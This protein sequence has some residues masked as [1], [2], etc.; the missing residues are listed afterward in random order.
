MDTTAMLPFDRALIEAIKD[1]VFIVSAEKNSVLKYAFFNQVVFERTHLTEKDTGKSFQEAHDHAVANLLNR[2]YGKVLAT[3]KSVVYQDTY[4]T[5]SGENYHSE[6]TL[7]PL[8]DEKGSCTHIIGIVKDI[9]SE[10]KANIKSEEAWIQ[11]KESQSRY[12]SLYENNADAI[13]T[14]DLAGQILAG[15]AVIKTVTGYTP[16]DLTGTAFSDYIIQKDNE[17]LSVYYRLALDGIFQDFRT[18]FLEKSGRLISVSVHFAPIEVKE[19]IVGVYAIIKDMRE[20]DQMINQ[21]V[22][23]EKR[24]RIIAENAQDVIVLLDYEGETLYVSPSAKRVYGF[25]PVE[26]MA[27]PPFYT[28]H[29][30]DIPYLRKTF[31]LAMQSGEPFLVELRQKHKTNGWIWTEVQGTPILDEHQQ[32]IHMLTITRDIT[33]Q[34]AQE[35]K[36]H[37][38]AY[39][40]SLTGL[41]NRRLLK[42]RLS[43]EI[44]NRPEPDD[45]LA[46]FLLDIDHFKTIN[47]R[48]GHDVGDAVIKEFGQRLRQSIREQDVVARLGGDEFVLL[49][50]TIK[51]KEQAEKMAEKIQAQMEAPWHMTNGSLEVTTSIGIALLPLAG[52]T[53]S[54]IL[55]NADLAMYEAKKAGKSGYR[56]HCL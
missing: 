55:K 38:Y 26:Y 24:F 15:N 23:S 36:L 33:L 35:T 39:H 16:A 21:Y 42:K 12:R 37:H 53:V 9:T 22:E 52:A 14:L 46:V 31:S 5:P 50:P 29:P 56:L 48:L 47:D 10:R 17:L 6:T 7:T 8:L 44:Q 41:P 30:E 45:I 13:F 49:L 25:D 3:K 18:Y 11:M 28:I 27:N 4:T 1:M 32:F 19:E 51:T 20:L 54:S 43:E 2:K 40:D 34:K